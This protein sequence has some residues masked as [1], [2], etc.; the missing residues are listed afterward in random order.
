MKL[1]KK[2][3]KFQK[4]SLNLLPDDT[5]RMIE[6][7]MIDHVV[8][9]FSDKKEANSFFITHLV[10]NWKEQTEYLFDSYDQYLE[11]VYIFHYIFK[12]WEQDLKKLNK[13]THK[14]VMARFLM[15]IYHFNYLL[16]KGIF[17]KISSPYEALQCFYKNQ[18]S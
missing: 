5:V 2:L 12:H 10:K 11:F 3:G 1:R 15:M 16:Q 6:Y 4:I 7:N 18:L 13:P 9:K 17:W 14:L 8:G